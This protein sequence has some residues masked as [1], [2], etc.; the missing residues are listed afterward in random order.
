MAMPPGSPPA[1]RENQLYEDSLKL[2]VNKNI[3]DV[4]ILL[5]WA[6]ESDSL[7]EKIQHTEQALAYLT[8]V[9]H[10]LRELHATR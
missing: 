3:E 1:P 10:T 8:D 7:R 6:Q 4:R 5:L 2:T 9:V